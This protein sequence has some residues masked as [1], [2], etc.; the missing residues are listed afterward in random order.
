MSDLPP[1]LQP[2]GQPN[3]DA[4]APQEAR[5]ASVT[6]REGASDAARA[7]VLMDPANQSLAEALKITFRLLQGGM[8]VL[9]ALFALS[10]FQS[11]REGQA[12]IRLLFGKAD[13]EVL[14]PGFKFAA[15]YPLG[16]IIKVETGAVQVVEDEA[17]WPEIRLRNGV[18]EATVDAITPKMA[19]DPEIDG[20]LVT[21]DGAIAHA[22]LSIQY[23][24]ADP[25]LYA[26]HILQNQERSIVR[27]AVQRGVMQAVATVSIDDLLKAGSSSEDS[28]AQR[29]RV[30]AQDTLDAL[31][32][33]IRI[34]SLTLEQKIPPRWL[35]DKFAEVQTAASKAAQAESAASSD[36][37]TILS[38]VAG[39]AAGILDDRIDAYELA[40]ESG[41][42]NAA[43]II[44]AEIDAILAGQIQGDDEL[45]SITVSGEVARMMS[46]ANQYRS[47][48]VS[49]STAELSSFNAQLAK[50]E[51]SPEL[52]VLGEWRDAFE[53]FFAK[54]FTQF[55][56]VPQGTNTL[57][58][59][60]N[61]DPEILN[62]I[63]RFNKQRDA[64]AARERREQE[65][66][67]SVFSVEKGLPVGDEDF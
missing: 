48:A 20:F 21:S 23:R 46:R 39:E 36:A 53:T 64:N 37:N 47:E 49:R 61:A 57:N 22:T 27:A 44:L 60:L 16:E 33:G 11:V 38:R 25:R 3:A 2:D 62:E 66:R 4:A 15:P 43:N 9:F 10:G 29:A 14:E 51:A 28:I 56:L 26:E 17:F 58:I 5:A 19:L 8:I 52:M 24:R 42:D 41:D 35:T 45:G 34:E 12:G 30:T 18:R 65:Q 7:R 6:L 63:D 50:Y 55:M 40:I 13:S 1:E 32:S 31:D 54:E 59:L 67:E